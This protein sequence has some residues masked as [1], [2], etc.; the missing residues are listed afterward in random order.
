MKRILIFIVSFGVVFLIV[1]GSVNIAAGGNHSRG[2]VM[3]A[4]GGGSLDEA[5][6]INGDAD[7]TFSFFGGYDKHGAFK[8]NFFAKRWVSGAGLASVKSTEITDIQV[9]MDGDSA[10]IMMTGIVDFMPAWSNKHSPGHRFTL[11]AWDNDSFGDGNDMI[12]FQVKR[13]FPDDYIRPAISLLEYCEVKG[14][15]ILILPQVLE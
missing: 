10:W 3:V 15:N 5:M 6:F 4:M 14:G 13:P 8:G 2:M 9:G 1:T 11:I 12:W 7:A